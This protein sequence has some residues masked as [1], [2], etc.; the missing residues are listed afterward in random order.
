M[1]DNSSI[2]NYIEISY[3]QPK[4]CACSRWNPNGIT[5]EDES[6]VDGYPMGLFIDRNNTVYAVN[7]NYNFVKEWRGGN[8][9]I[10]R[11]TFR[12]LFEPWSLFVTTDG[13]IYVDNGKDGAVEKWALNDRKSTIVMNT[14][15]ACSGLFVDI[16]NNLYCSLYSKNQVVKQ[17]LDPGKDMSKTVIAGY[18]GS[19]GSR[20]NMLCQPW[21]IF[22]TIKF[23][24]Y[25]ADCA[26]ERIQLFQSGQMI[27]KTV[28]GD[29]KTLGIRLSRPTGVI[30]DADDNLFI[31]DSGKNRIIRAGPNGFYCV[32]G[33][34]TAAGLA[35]NQLNVPITAAFDNVGNILITDKNNHRIQKFML[36]R[37]TDGK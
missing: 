35:S 3:N 14:N 4:L 24:L 27:G 33:C 23:E 25:V 31:V 1:I 12:N 2:F 37:N 16:V 32:I 10:T 18:D 29:I 6:E 21:G 22:V 17:S 36:I 28:V 11:I 13:T 9:N 8:T 5:F 7:G 26:N 19:C 34:S 20:A 15:S 30:V